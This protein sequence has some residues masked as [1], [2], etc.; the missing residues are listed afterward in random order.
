MSEKYYL[1]KR[2]SNCCPK[3]PLCPISYYIGHKKAKN[4]LQWQ[5]YNVDALKIYWASPKK[6]HFCPIFG[7]R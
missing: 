4:G 2:I 5:P 6:S 7:G 1:S 3:K